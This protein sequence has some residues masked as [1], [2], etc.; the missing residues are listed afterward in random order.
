MAEGSSAVEETKDKDPGMGHNQP[1]VVWDRWVK[2]RTFVRALEGTYGE[3]QSGLYE[4]PRVVST[5]DMK[6][7]GGPQA[8]GKHAINPANGQ[9][10]Q[11]IETHMHV[12]APGGYAQNHG[13]MNTATFYVL[14]GKGYDIHD[15]ERIEF[16]A[17]DMLLVEASCVHQH[18]NASDEEDL[19]VVVMKA[20]PLFLFMHM[21]FQKTVK[22]PP[23]DPVPG[24]ELYSPPEDVW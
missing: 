5:A 16:E 12:F 3:M 2:K 4:Q 24:M 23:S 8:Y 9:I 13:H 6:W 19:A 18:F 20:K 15:G 10:A 22:L 7:K 1:E 11:S 21:L 17:G 14:R